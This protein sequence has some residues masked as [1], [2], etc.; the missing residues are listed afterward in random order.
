MVSE[1]TRPWGSPIRK[2]SG[3]SAFRRLRALV[4]RAESQ[5]HS[6]AAES[7]LSKR[8][9]PAPASGGSRPARATM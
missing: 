3:V 6:W 7:M 8:R 4:S 5:L 9:W 2:V 1:G